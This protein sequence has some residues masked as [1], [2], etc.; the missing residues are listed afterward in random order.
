[1]LLHGAGRNA[2]EY[3][4]AIVSKA[5]EYNFIV[6]APEFST[7]N[8]PGGD[9]YNLGNVFLDGDN[10]TDNSLN[11]ESEWAFSVINP[12]F[13]FIKNKTRNSSERYH[14]IGHSAGAQFAHR[15]VM[16]KPNTNINHVILSAAGWYTVPDFSVNFPYGFQKSPLENINLKNLF[17]VS[18]SIQIG[19]LDNN[20]NAPGLRKNQ[21]TAIQGS[22]RFQRAYHFYNKSKS[23][24]DLNGHPFKWRIQTNEGLDHDFKAAIRIAADTIFN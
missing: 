15:F 22:N 1:M 23:F 19:E 13:N 21:Y 9:G 5:N 6:I 17:N 16:F 14:M 20:P 18:I 11:T 7:K 3:R 24:A 8:Y 4:D 12:L 10:P 2:R